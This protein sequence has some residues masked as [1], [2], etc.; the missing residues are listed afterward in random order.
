VAHLFFVNKPNAAPPNF[1]LNISTD[2]PQVKKWAF[3]DKVFCADSE[4]WMSPQTDLFWL[5]NY[6][7]LYLAKFPIPKKWKTPPKKFIFIFTS[8]KY[9]F[10]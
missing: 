2:F 9:R 3:S 6:K 4:C 10:F 8:K 5:K 7:N 1:S